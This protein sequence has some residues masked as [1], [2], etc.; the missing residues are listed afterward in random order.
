MI[1]MLTAHL[2]EVPT[3]I[4][5]ILSSKW[6]ILKP[7]EVLNIGDIMGFRE[8]RHWPLKTVKNVLFPFNHL[9]VINILG[10]SAISTKV[11]KKHTKPDPPPV[12]PIISG[13]GSMT[14]NIGV[15]IEHHII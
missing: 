2:S 4:T 3:V 11:H 1:F 5:L 15:F 13:S 12:R 14:E 8:I 7:D 6:A 9:K 10:K